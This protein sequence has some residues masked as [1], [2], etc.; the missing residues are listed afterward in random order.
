MIRFNKLISFLYP[1]LNDFVLF[2]LCFYNLNPNF[3]YLFFFIN[4]QL[5]IQKNS[6]LILKKQELCPNKLWMGKQKRKTHNTFKSCTSNTKGSFAWDKRLRRGPNCET[7]TKMHV[8]WRRQALD[9]KMVDG[10]IKNAQTSSGIGFKFSL[11]YPTEGGINAL[12]FPGKWTTKEWI[13]MRKK[14]STS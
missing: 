12:L 3:L 14:R 13:S 6:K 1:N 11:M 4:E 2:K 7:P 5:L 10:L 8:S 9:W